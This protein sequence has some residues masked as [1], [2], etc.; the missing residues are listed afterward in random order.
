[1]GQQCPYGFDSRPK[2][3]NPSQEILE[4]GFVSSEMLLILPAG[5]KISKNVSKWRSRTS[6]EHEID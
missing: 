4:R 6:F 5:H 2:H 3:I 1:R